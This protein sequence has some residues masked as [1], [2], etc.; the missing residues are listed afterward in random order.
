MKRLISLLLVFALLLGSAWADDPVDPGGDPNIEG[1]GG[2]MGEGTA[3]NWWRNGFDGI[4]VSVMRG[5]VAIRTFDLANTDW[6]GTIERC[7]PVKDKLTYKR[8]Q[9]INVIRSYTNVTL[10]NDMRLPTIIPDGGGNNTDAIRNYFTD[11][12]VVSYIA[13]NVGMDYDEL[14]SG[15]YKLLLEP[16][17]YMVYNGKWW[18]MSAT[19]AALY[20]VATGGD[21]RS[22]MPSLTHQ[23]L[24]LCMFLERADLGIPAWQSAAS[25]NAGATRGH[26]SDIDILNY[27]GVGIV[28]F[29]GLED[30]E[31]TPMPGA[32]VYDYTYRTDTDVITSVLI[33]NNLGRDMTPDSGDYVTF[34]IN[35]TTYHKQ[36]VCPEDKHQLVWLKWHTPSTAQDILVT[37]TQPGGDEILLTV[38]IEDL[39]EKT[40]P[41]PGYDGPGEGPGIT[42]TK[43]RPNFTPPAAPSWGN[44]T[45]ASWS[46]WIV[47]WEEEWVAYPEPVR[48]PKP[49]GTEELIYGE[50]VGWWDFSLATYEARLSVD[51]ELMPNAR[52]PTAVR[53]GGKYVMGSGYGVDAVCKVS[54]TGPSSSDVTKVQ[55]VVAVF[56]EFDYATYDRLLEPERNAYN[57]TWGFKSN[58]YSYYGEPVHFT[59]VW[60]PDGPYEV[61]AVVFDV[62]TPGGMLYVST[63]DSVT[64][65]G[66]MYDDWYIRSY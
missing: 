13:E 1:G 30:I 55:N 18:A 58:P 9:A 35:G 32:G 38:S 53:R 25:G 47:H 12:R 2:G 5:T 36:I 51:F 42:G 15:D 45:S 11:S 16:M 34:Q 54:V 50:W 44:N 28:S 43:Y 10:P 21:L 8:T 49:D 56:P 20:D 14:I 64:I 4:R 17:A 63:R 19:E 66:D 57:T 61:S 48:I 3:E 46:Q 23:N 37:V 62:W 7:F 39:Q 65:D 60:Y 27:L 24:P 26:Q 41:D 31:E 22:K 40:P 52:V 29:L 33:S 6:S 59:P